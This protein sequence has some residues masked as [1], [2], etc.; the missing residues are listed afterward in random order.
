MKNWLWKISGFIL[1]GIGYLGII[2]PGL[3]FSPFI[4]G[5]AICFS[6]SSPAMHK[7]L[8]N[9]KFFGPFLSN[10]VN[11]K[12]FPTKMKYMM[13]AVM[14][15]SLV[16]LWFTTHNSTTIAYSGGFMILVSI[17]AW[18]FPGS[19]NEYYERESSGKKIGWFK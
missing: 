11:N 16:I 17:W 14:S 4:V 8:Y 15:S 3:P 6:K 12:V 1:L 13:L 9:H 10:W 2:T 5:S 19:L 18:R 7:W